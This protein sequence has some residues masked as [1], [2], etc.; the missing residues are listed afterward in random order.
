[1]DEKPKTVFVREAT[2]LVKNASLLDA[3]SLNLSDMSIGAALATIGF[4][5]LLLPSVSGVNLVYGSLLAF[6]L[7]IPQIVIYT[8]M[9]RRIAKTGGDY[10]WLS[11]SFGG[12]FGCSVSFMG[13]TTETIAYLALISLSAV[14]AIGAVGALFYPYSSTLIGLATPGATP[15]P[16]FIVG[17]VLF[18][19]LIGINILK[20]KAGF[21]L[22]SVL[23]AIGLATTI[24][25]IL[26]LLSAGRSGV[27]SYVNA[28]NATVHTPTYSSL[29][30][31]YTGSTFNLGATL[32][33]IPFYAIFVYP[34]V[35]AA[36]AVGSEV[37]GKDSLK[38]AIPIS[39][40]IT[41]VLVT[42][43]FATMYY[44]GGLDF[45]NAALSNYPLVTFYSFNFWTLAMGVTSSVALQWIIGIGWILWTIAILAYGI[46]V[47]ARY[48]FGQSFDR[49]LPSALA[50]VS[51]RY[52]SPM[53]AHLLDLVVT[54]A[55]IGAASYLYGTFVSLYGAAVASMVYFLFVGLAA[56]IYGIRKEQGRAKGTLVTAGVLS[57]IVFGYIT[58]EFLAAPK[59]WGGNLFAYG[60]ALGT[61]VVGIAIYLAS[62]AY[63]KKNKGVDIGLAF[64]EIPPD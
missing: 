63:Q 31:S 32:S 48:L 26:T 12:L 22:V 41:M 29:A 52:S 14:F 23:T 5:M 20:P 16:Q 11:R 15:T 60:Y 55:L 57:A 7:L 44:V 50:Y 13:I 35:N 61:F 56:A 38:W 1:V 17:A 4:T 36:P 6:V 46:I 42:A 18:A 19:A 28:L 34:W 49:F 33:I 3:I 39:A 21:K 51:P 8:M 9:S 45:T 40:V 10:I 2:G 27:I 59:V 54:V 25:A 37:K 64:K 30:S 53:V 62:S 47:L 43:A 58:Y 24:I